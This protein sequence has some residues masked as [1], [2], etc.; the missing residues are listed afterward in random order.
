MIYWNQQSDSQILKKIKL[1]VK[2]I[3]IQFGNSVFQ[4][5]SSSI[6]TIVHNSKNNKGPNMS[7]RNDYL[8][9]NSLVIHF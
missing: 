8:G 5:G 4:F 6:Q 1:I 3:R 9:L 7:V 2:H